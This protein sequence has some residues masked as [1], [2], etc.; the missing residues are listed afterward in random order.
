MPD[1]TVNAGNFI[2]F[3]DIYTIRQYGKYYNL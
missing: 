3:S 2:R 1:F